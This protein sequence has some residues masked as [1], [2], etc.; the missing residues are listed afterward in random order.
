MLLAK[1]SKDQMP[2]A[3]S[4]T[5]PRWRSNCRRP[6]KLEK[7]LFQLHAS[8]PR[9]TINIIFS[10]LY[11]TWDDLLLKQVRPKTSCLMHAGL[12]SLRAVYFYPVASPASWWVEV[13]SSLSLSRD[14]REMGLAF[15]DLILTATLKKKIIAC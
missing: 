14:V 4:T 3:A 2:Q 13:L 1:R 6:S 5:A 12:R 11:G 10:P 7:D 9:F 15:P 8:V